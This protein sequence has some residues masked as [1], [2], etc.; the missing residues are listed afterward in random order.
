MWPEQSGQGGEGGGQGGGRAG[1]AGPCG[2]GED[3]GFPPWGGA[4]LTQ[5]R[6]GALW[7][8]LW[9]GQIRARV[10]AE[11]PGRRCLGWSRWALWGATQ[12]FSTGMQ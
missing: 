7:W 1:H 12:D 4:G 2:S 11:G 10:G 9:G 5:G 6:T 3:L 8:L